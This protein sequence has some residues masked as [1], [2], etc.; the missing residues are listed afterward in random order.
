MHFISFT[1]FSKFNA[2]PTISSFC[3]YYVP[4]FWWH[5]CWHYEK[6][7]KHIMRICN[8]INDTREHPCGKLCELRPEAIETR[9]RENYDPGR[10]SFHVWL[11]ARRQMLEI[12]GAP[13]NREWIFRLLRAIKP[14]S[15]TM[16]FSSHTMQSFT[17]CWEVVG[18][19]E[20][21]SRYV[22]I[23]ALLCL[24][25]NIYLGGFNI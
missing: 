1:L 2:L 6:T 12:H 22:I 14:A 20:Q 13:E 18:L 17:E 23:N 3:W 5:F 25:T 11:F 24:M 16:I 19:Y 21:I 9:E 15:R 4:I 10:R 7:C 8:A